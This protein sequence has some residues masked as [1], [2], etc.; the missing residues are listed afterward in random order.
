M[1]LEGP[2]FPARFH[3]LDRNLQPVPFGIPGELYIAGPNVSKGYTNRPD[4]TARAFMRDPS[5]PAFEIDAG[6]GHLYRTGDSFRLNRD[7]TV[8]ILGRIGG[9]RQVKIRG[10]RTELEE[11]ENAIWDAYE[12]SDDEGISK[13]S[14]AAVVYHRTKG[15]D[16]GILAAYLAPQD[17]IPIT[18]EKQRQLTEYLRLS[19]KAVLPPHMLPATYV[20]MDDLPCTV[21]GKVD[22]KTIT[23][24]PAPEVTVGN[25][26]D[27]Q[28]KPL[29]EL[30]A[31]VASIWKE[32]LSISGDLSST[33]EFFTL[34]GHSLALVQLQQKIQDACGV[35]LS[36]A[37]MFAYPSIA[38]FEELIMGDPRYRASNSSNQKNVIVKHEVSVNVYKVIC[39]GSNVS[40]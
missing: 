10:M 27:T 18:E 28:G 2:F 13:L 20:F 33:D 17:R 15:S 34:G 38:G 8:D 29:T 3:I 39:F 25:G 9:D 24:W 12:A 35:T 1:P 22:Y 37:D 16:T 23:G 6:Y 36:L 14:L 26:S 30:Q 5:A 11:I 7:G 40:L 21:S 31:V 4:V 19:L 32:I